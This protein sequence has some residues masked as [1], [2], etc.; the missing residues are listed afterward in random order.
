MKCTSRNRLKEGANT[1]ERSR[2]A[3]VISIFGVLD[4][5]LALQYEAFGQCETR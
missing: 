2:S 4:V 3:Y 5:A 1:P